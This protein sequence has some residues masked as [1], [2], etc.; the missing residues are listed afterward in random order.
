M[1]IMFKKRLG[2]V[3][4]RNYICGRLFNWGSVP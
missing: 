1:S 3:W 2:W 4:V